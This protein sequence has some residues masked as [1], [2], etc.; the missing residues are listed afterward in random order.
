MQTFIF[1][2]SQKPH[3]SKNNNKT[4]N[5]ATRMMSWHYLRVQNLITSEKTPTVGWRLIIWF[6]SSHKPSCVLSYSLWQRPHVH[7]I[8]TIC[9][10]QFVYMMNQDSFPAV[11][12]CHGD[13]YVTSQIMMSRID[14]GTFLTWA[15][16]VVLKNTYINI[17]RMFRACWGRIRQ[18]PKTATYFL[19]D[20]YSRFKQSLLCFKYIS[21]TSSA[22]QHRLTA[23]GVVC[24]WVCAYTLRV[25][26]CVC[27]RGRESV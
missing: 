9:F 25:Y 13:S 20:D 21:I 2:H 19:E 5:H 14:H 1:H 26:V 22:Q 4:V 15:A 12:Y 10:M 6:S 27:E 24:V 11:R 7:R 17:H 16:A 8:S 23:A 3:A 18:R